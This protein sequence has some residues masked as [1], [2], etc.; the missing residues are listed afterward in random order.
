MG[1]GKTPLCLCA[2]MEP[3]EK[4][5]FLGAF[6]KLP[7]RSVY[8]QGTSRFPLYGFHKHLYLSIFRKYVRKIQVF[9]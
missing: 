1:G 5:T 6:A 4:T 9:F 8:M 2:F 3:K 7:C